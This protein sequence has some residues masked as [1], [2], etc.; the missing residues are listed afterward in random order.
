MEVYCGQYY[1][2]IFLWANKDFNGQKPHVFILS[3]FMVKIRYTL[4]NIFMG[5]LNYV[6]YVTLPSQALLPLR[7]E[8]VSGN[9]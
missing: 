6:L 5:K 1:Q 9:V 2:S 3:M 4:A 8:E 7:R